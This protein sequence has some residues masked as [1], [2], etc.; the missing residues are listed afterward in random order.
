MSKPSRPTTRRGL[1]K[2][3]P[4]DDLDILRDPPEVR[5]ERQKILRA[6]FCGEPASPAQPAAQEP[7]NREADKRASVRP[8]KKRTAKKRATAKRR[9]NKGRKRKRIGTRPLAG[10]Q[11]MVISEELW[12][13]IES[14]P[15][16]EWLAMQGV[17]I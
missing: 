16:H 7:A 8:A 6:F 14:I 17:P 13:E 2:S 9:A 3:K 12:D 11:T 4:P 1:P 10:D 15:L 5:A